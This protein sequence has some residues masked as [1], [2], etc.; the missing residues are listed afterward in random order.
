MLDGI[1]T[2]AQRTEQTANEDLASFQRRRRSLSRDK[3]QCGNSALHG[4]A[5]GAGHPAASEAY[6]SLGNVHFRLGQQ[7][8]D[9][10][11]VGV[12]EGGHRAHRHAVDLNKADRC[13]QSGVEGA[14]TNRDDALIGA[15]REE[16][17]DDAT[18]QRRYH[19]ALQIMEQLLQSN[20]GE[21]F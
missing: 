6:Y 2:T 16:T 19:A 1:R 14:E 3:L 15:P 21:P 13:H 20:S 7:A 4:G 12:L 5:P 9:L 11:K 10:D 17:A 8:E 18:R